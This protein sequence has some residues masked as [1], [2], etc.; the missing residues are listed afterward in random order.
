[1]GASWIWG[2]GPGE[3]GPS[4][5]NGSSCGRMIESR[6]VGVRITGGL[7]GRS[8][9]SLVEGEVVVWDW[10]MLSFMKGHAVW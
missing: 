2:G 9:L 6:S 8:E 7:L 5:T 1:M 3:V 10:V 4:T